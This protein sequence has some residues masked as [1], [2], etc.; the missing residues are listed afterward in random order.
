MTSTRLLARNTALNL[1]GQI[2]PLIVAVAAVPRL[3][4]ALGSDRFGVLMLAWALIGYFGLFDFGIG[5]ALTQAVSEALGR[6]D[7]ARLREVSAVALSFMFALGCAGAVVIA[8]LTPW[9]CYDLLKMDNVLRSEAAESF[10][11]LAASLPFVLATVGLRGLFEAHQHFGLATALRVPYAL[12]NFVGPLLII[13]FT[14]SLVPIVAALVVG[15]AATCAAHVWF[16]MRRYPWLR[17]ASLRNASSML[18]LLRLG[19]WMTVSNII[20]PMMTYMD[21]FVIGALL[22]MTAVTYYGT[23]FEVIS[24]VMFVPAAVLG[25]FFPAFATTFVQNRVH[26][27]TILDRSARF[28]LIAMFPV[29]LVFVTMAREGLFVWVGPEFA[30][31]STVVLQVLAVGVLINS[32]GQ[33]PSSLLQAI[34]RADLTAKAHMSEVLIYAAMLFGFARLYG[35]A[36]VAMAWTMRLVIDTGIL[37]WLARRH[38]PEAAPAIMTSIMWL[39]AMT[40]VLVLVSLPTA[41]VPRATGGAAVLAGF[42]VLAWTRIILPPER[43]AI[44]E[45]FQFDRAKG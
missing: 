27:A 2:A 30:R 5:R 24:K 25:V 43:A 7:A 9:L 4:A 14:H 20:S 1:F 18:P 21:R 41:T 6:G 31:Q 35:L 26:T 19:G 28:M 37:A 16:S 45:W 36:G 40:A 12:F 10:Y 33:I 8:V 44:L 42:V 17:E 34:G 3:I 13:P 11:L 15:R 39:T 38:L 32:F 23:P 29:V 22:S